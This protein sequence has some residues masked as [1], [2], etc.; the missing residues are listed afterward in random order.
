MDIANQIAPSRRARI[1]V[2]CFSLYSFDI[3]PRDAA[4]INNLR[5]AVA[6]D[7]EDA[8]YTAGCIIHNA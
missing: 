3:N 8:R 2:Q 6:F 7:V 4:S 1:F 5:G